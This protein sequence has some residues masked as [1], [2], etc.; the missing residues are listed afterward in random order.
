MKKNTEP[1]AEEHIKAEEDIREQEL[2]GIE[3]SFKLLDEL[4]ERIEDEDT[5]LEESFRLYEEGLRLVKHARSQIDRVEQDLK[6]LSEDDGDPE[7][8]GS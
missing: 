6:V 8:E 7:G 4:L 1:K 2:P 3:E 5:P